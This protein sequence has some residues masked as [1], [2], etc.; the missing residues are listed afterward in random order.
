MLTRTWL[1][2]AG[3]YLQNLQ[4]FFALG[5]LLAP[6]V[7][8]PFLMEHLSNSSNTPPLSADPQHPST[9]TQPTMIVRVNATVDDAPARSKSRV[10]VPFLITCGLLLS[11]VGAFVLKICFLEF[12]RV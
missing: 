10:N 3:P 11:L 12:W 6:F 7:T 1:H 9:I 5:G 4:L 8:E 2:R